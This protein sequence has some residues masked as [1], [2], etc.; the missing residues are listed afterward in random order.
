MPL[1]LS[2]L[3]AKYPEVVVVRTEEQLFHAVLTGAT[4]IE[5]H[6]HLHLVNWNFTQEDSS[7]IIGT[8]GLYTNVQSLQVR[9]C[10]H[11]CQRCTPSD[12]LVAVCLRTLVWADR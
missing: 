7:V 10:Q 9:I 1:H 8:D 5:L 3:Q 4:H 6:N 11:G 2:A 12:M